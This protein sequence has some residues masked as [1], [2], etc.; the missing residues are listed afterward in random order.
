MNKLATLNDMVANYHIRVGI[1]GKGSQSCSLCYWHKNCNKKSANVCTNIDTR[2]GFGS[3][4]FLMA[5]TDSI[6]PHDIE[7]LSNDIDAIIS[8]MLVHS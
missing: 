6:G 1:N 5:L 8:A 7:A 4:V 3:A 2:L